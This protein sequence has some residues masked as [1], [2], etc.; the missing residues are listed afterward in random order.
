MA[1]SYTHAYIY[2]IREREFLLLNQ[3]IYKIGRSE[4]HAN[5]VI[6]RIA[7]G[8]K[9]GSE[10]VLVLHTPLTMYKDVESV[11]KHMFCDRFKK[12][13]DG[14]EYFEGD[15]IQMMRIINDVVCHSWSITSEPTISNLQ[16]CLALWKLKLGGHRAYT[17]QNEALATSCIEKFQQSGLAVVEQFI[18]QMKRD[19]TDSC[20]HNKK[21]EADI[22]SKIL[23][24]QQEIASAVR[25]LLRIGQ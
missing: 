11:L 25:N 1:A 4:Q 23:E 7:T 21:I 14:T 19:R 9:K 24:K 3:P 13:D 10:I 20:S 2:L 22:E 6:K 18:E 17:E 16:R 15:P 5:R 8:Y 12:H